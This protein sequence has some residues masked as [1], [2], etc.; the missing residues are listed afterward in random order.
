MDARLYMINDVV[1]DI[2][3]KLETLERYGVLSH[4]ESFEII[5]IINE[6]QFNWMTEN[7]TSI[8]II[9]LLREMS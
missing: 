7:A 1:N 2:T 3:E 6:K 8:D 4:K 5:E 9:N